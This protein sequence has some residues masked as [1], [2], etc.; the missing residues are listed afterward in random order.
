MSPRCFI[1]RKSAAKGGAATVDS[2]HVAQR[3]LEEPGFYSE[4]STVA[5][6][7]SCF[8]THDFVLGAGMAVIQPS[9]GKVLVVNDTRAPYLV[10]PTRPQRHRRDD[11]AVCSPRGIRGG[12]AIHGFFPTLPS[13]PSTL[14]SRP[15]EAEK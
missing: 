9:T 10:S 5:I 1:E 15:Y 2:D 12:M 7:D 8:W 11:R 14:L 6:P 4:N 13:P 3:V